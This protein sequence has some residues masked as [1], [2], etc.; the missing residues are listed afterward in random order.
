M[1]EPV[2]IKIPELPAA[3]ELPEVVEEVELEEILK[4]LQDNPGQQVK[5]QHLVHRE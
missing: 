4:K 3:L 2:Q 1:L 5:R